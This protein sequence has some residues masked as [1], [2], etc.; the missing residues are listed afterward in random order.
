M[1]ILLSAGLI[2]WYLKSKNQSN[3]VKYVG[4]GMV[5][6]ILVDLWGVDK[7]YINND[8]FK[9][10]KQVAEFK[11]TAADN[12]ILQDKDVSY[13]VLNLNSPFQ[14]ANTSYYHKSIGGYSAAKLRR[15]Q[16]LIDH[17][18]MGELGVVVN[19][20]QQARSYE[21]LANVGINTP[22]LNMLNAR[23][24]I[25]DPEQPPIINKHA[26]GNAW[27]V[28]NYEFVENADAEIAALNRIDP[29]ETA[30][31]DKKFAASLNN[32]S[33]Q[34]DD[35]GF[36]QMTHY[37][38]VEVHYKSQAAT[39][40]LAVFSEIYYP[41]GW[42]AYIDGNKA[43]HFRADWTLRG[44]IVPAG[45]HEIVFKF[46]PQTYITAMRIASI[47]SLIIL[48][49]VVFAIGWTAWEKYG[50]KKETI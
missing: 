29:L 37:E 42:E 25:F 31:V 18:L 44:M 39:D 41:H 33:I 47:S 1:F 20:L 11:K 49:L 4:I 22:S 27:F 23:Y 15:Y 30:V 7:R 35:N 2:F 36:I 8:S 28:N 21:D 26:Y 48:L 24:I 16:E 10:E 19:G 12:F 34:K 38:P 32:A 6:L 13:R 5:V 46:I 40:Q 43:E 9:P 50:K 14:D 3:V 17:R 45:E